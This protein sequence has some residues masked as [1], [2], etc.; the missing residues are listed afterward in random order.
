MRPCHSTIV[1][2]TLPTIVGELGG[3]ALTAW[4]VVEG[5]LARHVVPDGVDRGSREPSSSRSRT[6]RTSLASEERGAYRKNGR[7]T[8]LFLALPLH[9]AGALRRQ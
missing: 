7:L 9:A 1:A 4:P 3:L 6:M 8:L 2:I 5:H